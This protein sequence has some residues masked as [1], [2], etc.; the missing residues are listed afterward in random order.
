MIDS[1][2]TKKTQ[3]CENALNIH[4]LDA[5]HRLSEGKYKKVFIFGEPQATATMTV[6]QLKTRNIIGIYEIVTEE[7]YR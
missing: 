2:P 6:E 1:A 3:W 4:G 7:Q 5:I